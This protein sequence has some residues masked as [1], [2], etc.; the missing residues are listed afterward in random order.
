MD[1]ILHRLSP[2][3]LNKPAIVSVPAAS[4][5]GFEDGQSDKM[6]IRM[7]PACFGLNVAGEKA[8]LFLVSWS[9]N[10]SDV[11]TADI[12]RQIQEHLD[13]RKL[14]EMLRK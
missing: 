3:E 4:F 11:V 2:N 8:Q 5:Q 7:N 9:Y 13:C 12:D 14:Q 1:N 6:L 10:P